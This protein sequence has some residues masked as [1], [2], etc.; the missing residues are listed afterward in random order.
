M[1]RRTTTALLLLAMTGQVQACPSFD[2]GASY[3]SEYFCRQLDE[4]TVP[5][6]RTIGDPPGLS[7]PDALTPP[8][9]QWMEI[10]EIRHAWRS[11]PAK[12]LRLIQRIRDA[13]GRPVN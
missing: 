8:D 6:T 4:Y 3:L 11:D 2:L 7:S 10:P 9:P 1:A 12:T 5:P 13:G